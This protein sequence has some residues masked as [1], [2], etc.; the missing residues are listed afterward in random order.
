MSDQRQRDVT[1]L[2]YKYFTFFLFLPNTAYRL[3]CLS[4]I[5]K[6]QDTINCIKPIPTSDPAT[7]LGPS[8]HETKA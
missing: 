1:F 5:L 7:I 6:V 2:V 8:E 4:S 3:V